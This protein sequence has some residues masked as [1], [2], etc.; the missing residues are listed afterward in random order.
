MIPTAISQII[1]AT[2]KSAAGILLALAF[3]PHGIAYA[4]AAAIA[5][6][7]IGEFFGLMF[8]FLRTK[9]GGAG[10]GD[11]NVTPAGNAFMRSAASTPSTPMRKRTIIKTIA[12]ESL[13]V[14]LAALSM[15]LNPFI[16]M[17]TIPNTINAVIGKNKAYFLQNFT[18]GAHGGEAICDVGSFIYGSYTGITLPIFALA[19]SVTAMLGKSALPE[20]SASYNKNSPQ[21]IH[22]LRI[23]FKGT[24]MVGLPICLGLAALAE[25][26]LSL[27]YFS[28]P[29]EVLVST[30]PLIALGLGGISL[31]L[32]GMLFSIFLAMGRADLQIKLM[33]AGAAIKLSV[34][35]YLI[36]IPHINVTGAAIA[37]VLSYS[38][39]SV[40]GLIL[41]KRMINEN[42]GILRHI[43]QPLTF[44]LLCGVTAYICYYYAFADRTDLLRLA[45]SI[46]AGALVYL[47]LTLIFNL[48]LLPHR[49]AYPVQPRRNARILHR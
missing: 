8:L 24:F 6:V 49:E 47:T 7:T 41:L 22:S 12:R 9:F 4:A 46:A 31:I 18:Y 10:R 17:M 33:L 34:N 25:P 42:I 14:T 39:I 32:A 3:M 20:I 5:G 45:M 27:L 23:L 36:R 13:P 15:N 35:L 16:D 26:I 37:T 29:A 44:A 21:L 2:V 1:E 40:I 28:K 11:L 38:V 19:T 30:P 48:H 43:A